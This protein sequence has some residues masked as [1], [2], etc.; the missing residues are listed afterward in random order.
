MK[1]NIRASLHLYFIAGTQ[2]MRHLSGDPA[3]NLLNILRQALESGI[4]C[5]QFRDKGQFSLA[6]QPKAQADLA[7]KCRRLCHDYQIPF[8]MNDDVELGLAVGADGIHIGQSDGNVKQII[9]RLKKQNLIFGLSINTLEQLQHYRHYDAIDY[10]GI[11]PIFPT[12]SKLDHSAALGVDFL[13][14][15]PRLAIDKPCVAIGGIN[16]ANAAR[17]RQSGIDGLAVIS[18]ITQ[19]PD[20]PLAVRQLKAAPIILNNR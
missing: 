8:I 16:T 4:S 11:G 5:F 3:D 17:L 12:A 10:F 15:L 18:A 13:D 9:E 19:A 7:K 20:I 14:N 2:D 6:A 1:V